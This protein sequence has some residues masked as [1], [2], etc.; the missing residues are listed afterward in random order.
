ME[1]DLN[2]TVSKNIKSSNEQ[3]VNCV[4][5]AETVLQ[6]NLGGTQGGIYTK[7]QE[8]LLGQSPHRSDGSQRSQAGRLDRV[9]GGQRQHFFL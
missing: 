1:T 3:N 9:S 6:I 2:Q 4:Q 7:A 5:K 8:G